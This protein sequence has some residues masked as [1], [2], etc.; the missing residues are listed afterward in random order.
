MYVSGNP[1]S[2]AE[3]KRRIAAGEPLVV[4]QPGLGKPP[5]NRGTATVEGPHF[6]EPHRWYGMVEITDG[7]VTRVVK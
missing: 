1:K 3:L 6:P 4:F 2:K 7:I 5:P